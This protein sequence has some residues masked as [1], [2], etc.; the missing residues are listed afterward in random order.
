M[1]PCLLRTRAPWRSAIFVG[2]L[3]GSLVAGPPAARGAAAGD[4]A[5]QIIL[6]GG[7]MTAHIKGASLQQVMAEVSRV[8]G[9]QL[10]WLHGVG[11]E[12]V[13]VEFRALPV[14]EA[15]RR[16]LG[17]HNFLLVYTATRK[18]AQL[19]QIWITSR[20]QAS[21][22]PQRFGQAAG[23]STP[24]PS[25]EE[26]PSVIT[27]PP[28]AVVTQT[29]LSDQDLAARLSAIEALG[30]QSRDDPRAHAILSR[31]AASDPNPQVREVAAAVLVGWE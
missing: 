26:E 23:R 13:T 24:R 21:G 5:G 8:S 10:W 16:L 4:V 9:A 14:A 20:S 6:H 28:L 2:L 3:L 15:L 30:Q 12:V 19:T 22:Q 1:T 25:T 31:L 29:A 7:R 18:G 17:P 27:P 11:E